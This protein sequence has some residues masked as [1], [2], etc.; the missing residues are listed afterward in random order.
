MKQDN[1]LQRRKEEK[2]ELEK[3]VVELIK[4]RG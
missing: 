3:Q 1:E 4:V 2:K